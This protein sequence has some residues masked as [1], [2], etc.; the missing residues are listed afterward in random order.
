MAINSHYPSMIAQLTE[1][2]TLLAQTELMSRFQMGLTWGAKRDGSIVTD[3]DRAMQ[4]GLQVALAQQWPHIGFLGEEMDE[5]E[6]RR[7]L[8]PAGAMGAHDGSQNA[9]WCLD[10]LDGT[11]NFAAGIPFFSVSLALIENGQVSLGVIYDPVREECFSAYRGGSVSLNGKPP[12]D[13]PELDNPT[14]LSEMIAVV[15]LKRLPKPLAINIAA[16]HPFRSQRNFGSCALEWCWLAMQRFQLYLHGGQKL[17]DYAAGR[18]ILETASGVVSTIDGQAEFQISLDA[19]PVIAA[20]N[21]QHYQRW[22]DWV[23]ANKS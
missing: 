8:M 2:I 11:T 7:I 14:V 22:Y 23:A 16:Q 18:L 13:A 19:Q 15:D 21:Q 4:Q 1:M 3:A 5:I 9:Y 6:Q 12:A 17:W 20:T 10:P